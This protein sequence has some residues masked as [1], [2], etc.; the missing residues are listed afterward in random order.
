MSVCLAATV[1]VAKPEEKP[2]PEL[3]VEEDLKTAESNARQFGYPGE[4]QN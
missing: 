4:N 3:V 1:T 2:Q